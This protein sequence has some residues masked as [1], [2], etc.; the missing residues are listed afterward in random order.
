VYL[1]LTFEKMIRCSKK[2]LEEILNINAR[3]SEKKNISIIIVSHFLPDKID[4]IDTLSKKFKI[5]FIIPK[6]NSIDK[7]VFE[8]LSRK[9]EIFTT[10]REYLYENKEQILE[11]LKA[12][13]NNFVIIDI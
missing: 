5:E 6:P 2:Y 8:V 1:F 10:T 3:N 11:K 13:E 7:D 9:Y 12:I 4:F